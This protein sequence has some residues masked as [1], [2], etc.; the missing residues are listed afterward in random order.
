[1][2]RGI[3]RWRQ[4]NEYGG[5]YLPVGPPGSV[6]DKNKMHDHWI[7][8]ID[9][10]FPLVFDVHENTPK[11]G[12]GVTPAL[13]GHPTDRPI[14]HW[15]AVRG[16]SVAGY[17]DNKDWVHYVDSAYGGQGFTVYPNQP[18]R[19]YTL[20]QG[21]QRVSF[22]NVYEMMKVRGYGYVW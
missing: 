3:N 11:S 5:D 17:Y 16:Y 8:D 4:N 2:Q 9:A 19:N 20:T 18:W 22:D 1:M 14:S 6:L 7:T 15:F 13:P 12:G 21:N 10:A